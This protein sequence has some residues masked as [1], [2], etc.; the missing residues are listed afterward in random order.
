MENAFCM[1]NM[2]SDWQNKLEDL[3]D[4]YHMEG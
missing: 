2:E 3:G 4:E 1:Q